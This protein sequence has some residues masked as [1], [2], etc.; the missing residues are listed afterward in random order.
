MTG[1]VVVVV[2]AENVHRRIVVQAD[3][4]I[5]NRGIG[6]VHDQE[7][8]VADRGIVKIARDRGITEAVAKIGE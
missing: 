2:A 4:E 7:I 1:S 5:E 6:T 3:R 8:N